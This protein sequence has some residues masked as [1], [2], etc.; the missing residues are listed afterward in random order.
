MSTDYPG[1]IDSLSNPSGSNYLDDGGVSHAT[2]HANANDA[3][4]A[5]ETKVGTGSSTPAAGKVLRST[6]AGASAWGQV[7]VTTDIAT[8]TSADLRALLSDETGTGAAVF[9]N[10]PTIV[11][12]TI[13]S[14]TNAQHD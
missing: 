9:A 11:T 3:I 14:F 12:P 13:A 5:I 8:F 2:Q 1:A 10:S 7:D 6:G 4:E